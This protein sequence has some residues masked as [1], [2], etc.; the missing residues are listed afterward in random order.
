MEI[1]VFWSCRA[2]MLK[3]LQLH[4]IGYFYQGKTDYTTPQKTLN[5]F[6]SWDQPCIKVS[7]KKYKHWLQFTS[8]N[9]IKFDAQI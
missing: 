6:H 5:K 2:V 1:S 3:R 8:Q 4:N 7:F 9:L